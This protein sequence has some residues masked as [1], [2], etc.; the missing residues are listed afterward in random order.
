MGELPLPVVVT[1]L[2]IQSSMVARLALNHFSKTNPEN[3]PLMR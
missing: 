3:Y 2:L 1:F